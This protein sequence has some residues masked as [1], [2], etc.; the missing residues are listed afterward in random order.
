MNCGAVRD[1][2]VERALGTLPARDVSGIDRHLMWCAACRKEAS[3]MDSAASVFAFGVEQHDPDPVLES[4]VV[5]AVHGAAGKRS[6][7]VAPRRGRLAIAAVLAAML[8]VSGLGWGAVMAGR[9]ARSDEAALVTTL[10]Q[11]SAAE[12]FSR[13]LAS[14]EFADP[15]GEVFLGTLSPTSPDGGGGSA[16]TLVSPTILDMAVVLVNGVPH[17]QRKDVP[18][19]VWLRGADHASL[20]VGRIPAL[21]SA[22]SGIVWQDLD[23]DLGVFDRVVVRDVHGHTVMRG[24]IATRAPL[25]S[26][27]P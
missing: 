5:A 9:A 14:S 15:D 13:I 6:V 7:H 4:R 18:F 2:L 20:E 21:D 3:E 8:A 16:L 12:K 1:G 17:A 22:G 24:L 26:P 10:R 25:S 27:S 11:Q 19:T 23:R